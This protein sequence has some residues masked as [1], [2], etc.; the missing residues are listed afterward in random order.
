MAESRA[1][2]PE[3]SLDRF[4]RGWIAPPLAAETERLYRSFETSVYPLDDIVVSVRSRVFLDVIASARPGSEVV[5]APCGMV[6]YAYLSSEANHYL[7]IDTQSVVDY[8][9]CRAHRL[10][11]GRLLPT[12]MVSYQSCDLTDLVALDSVVA[13]PTRRPR[14]YILE[15]ISYYLREDQWWNFVDH[16]ASLSG[17]EDVMAFDFWPASDRMASIYERFRQFCMTEAGL[18]PT[19]FN[20]LDE[21]DIRSFFGSTSVSIVDPSREAHTRFQICSLHGSEILRDTVAVVGLA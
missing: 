20:F 16:V 10:S 18:G 11:T 5:L 19:A 3:L 1:R 15:G 2:R 13:N 17:P 9:R 14:T 7:E 12:R 4:A 6:S 21:T 8:K